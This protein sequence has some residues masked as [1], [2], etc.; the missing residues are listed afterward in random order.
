[1]SLQC[2]PEGGCDDSLRC[3]DAQAAAVR[4]KFDTQAGALVEQLRQR[5]KAN[6][7]MAVSSAALFP[8]SPCQ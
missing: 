3:T 7:P 2:R 5:H 1:M 4:P 8:E 6:S